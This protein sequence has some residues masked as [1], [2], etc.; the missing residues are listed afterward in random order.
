M[1]QYIMEKKSS[2]TEEI[3]FQVLLTLAN[4]DLDEEYDEEDL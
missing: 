2:I 3:F 1:I 4:D